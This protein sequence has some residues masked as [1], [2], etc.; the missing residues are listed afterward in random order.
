MRS[1]NRNSVRRPRFFEP[2]PF[3][4][5]RTSRASAGVCSRADDDAGSKDDAEPFPTGLID[6]LPAP[7][8]I[9]V[10]WPKRDVH[11]MPV[12]IELILD[13]LSEHIGRRMADY[14]LLN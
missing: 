7:C 12:S 11:A 1:P 6:W 14:N 4:F 10:F 9:Q 13:Q 5:G 8:H 2:I 3:S